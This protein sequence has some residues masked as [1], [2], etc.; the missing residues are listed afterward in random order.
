MFLPEKNPADVL[1]YAIKSYIIKA[2]DRINECKITAMCTSSMISFRRTGSPSLTRQTED[3]PSEE[4]ARS[5]ET[6]SQHVFGGVRYIFFPSS[7]RAFIHRHN[8]F[9]CHTVGAREYS[10][11]V[12]V[13]VTLSFRVHEIIYG[14]TWRTANNT[15]NANPRVKSTWSRT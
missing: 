12:T 5:S 13:L 14:L 15:A 11:L 1:D 3:R 4:R 8:K 2:S 10:V 9:K 7:L 6:T